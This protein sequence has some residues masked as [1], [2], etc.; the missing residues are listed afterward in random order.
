MFGIKIILKMSL[1]LT[2]AAF[3]RSK[4]ELKN[5]LLLNCYNISQY[6]SILYYV[7]HAAFGSWRDDFQNCFFY[8][9]L[10][11]YIYIYNTFLNVYLWVKKSLQL[12]IEGE[13]S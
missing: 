10:S 11:P 1:L 4:I 13:Y 6:Y 3:I 8:S 12:H 5:S 9:S 7:T 2:K